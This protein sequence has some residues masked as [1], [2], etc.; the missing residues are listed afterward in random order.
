MTMP[1]ATSTHGTPNASQRHL[2]G[3]PLSRAENK[4][5]DHI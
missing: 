4:D 5:D 1:D 3:W 2:P